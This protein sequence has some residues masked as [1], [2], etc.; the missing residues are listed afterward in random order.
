MVFED[1]EGTLVNRAE[2]L[3]DCSERKAIERMA[4]VRLV[5]GISQVFV[6]TFGVVLLVMTGVNRFTLGAAVVGLGLTLLSRFL[7]KGQPSVVL[8]AGSGTGRV[9]N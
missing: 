1:V 9:E 3:A 7:F 5:L 6:A 2:K 8:T 4:I